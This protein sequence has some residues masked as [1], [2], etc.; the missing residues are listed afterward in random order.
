MSNL[1]RLYC[2]FFSM[3]VAVRLATNYEK[4]ADEAL[5][6]FYCQNTFTIMQV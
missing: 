2:K 3:F 5:L 6:P 4:V 1:T